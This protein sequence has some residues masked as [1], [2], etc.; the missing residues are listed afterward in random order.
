MIKRIFSARG[1]MARRTSNF[2]KFA[3]ALVFIA[4]GQAAHADTLV[5]NLDQYFHPTTNIVSPSPITVTFMDLATGGVRMGIQA[6]AALAPHSIMGMYFNLDTALNP[7]SLVFSSALFSSVGASSI[8]T[9]TNAYKADGDGYFDIKL[10]YASGFNTPLRSVYDITG[11][12]GLN[13]SS[14]IGMSDPGPGHGN[15]GPFPIAAQTGSGWLTASFAPT[16]TVGAIPEPEVYA[17]MLAG[18]ALMSFV[19]RRRKRQA[20][21]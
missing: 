15:S 17:M 11:P 2:A 21:A 10:S 13:V 4:T 16:T 14:F 12:S 3:V 5:Y 18:L 9:G 6:N 7:T 8:Q 19:A 20:A 1:L